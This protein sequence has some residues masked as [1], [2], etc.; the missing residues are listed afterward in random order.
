MGCLLKGK[1]KEGQVGEFSNCMSVFL[2]DAKI[3]PSLSRDATT[4]VA[5]NMLS[6]TTGNLVPMKNG[7]VGGSHNQQATN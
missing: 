3:N 1:L 2:R 6:E 5:T 7:G 4:K